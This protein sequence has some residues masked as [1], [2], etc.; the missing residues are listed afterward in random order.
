MVCL[1]HSQER[2]LTWN[3]SDLVLAAEQAAVDATTRSL[4]LEWG[5]D[6][7]IRSNTVAP[8]PIEGTPGM[9]KLAPTEVGVEGSEMVPLKRMGKPWDIAMAVVFLAS[10]AGEA[11]HI[12]RIMLYHFPC[13]SC[14]GAPAMLC[15]LREASCAQ[16][17]HSVV[18]RL[19]L[20][21]CFFWNAWQETTSTGLILW[22]MEG[23]GCLHRDSFQRTQ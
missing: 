19:V 1:W 7:G 10:D 6:Y 14:I 21:L 2:A 13:A 18:L 3:C 17:M 23:V 15:C 12:L 5:T 4:A 8:G 20:A 22:W 9:A 11:L 16:W